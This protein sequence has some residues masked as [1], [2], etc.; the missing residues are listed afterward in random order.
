M[1]TLS[2][3]AITDFCKCPT[4]LT[5]SAHTS[6]AS[7]LAIPSR[8]VSSSLDLSFSW[9]LS[10]S[11]EKTWTNHKL[12]KCSLGATSSSLARLVVVFRS[13]RCLASQKRDKLPKLSLESLRRNLKLI[14]NKEVP[15]RTSPGVLSSATCTSATPRDSSMY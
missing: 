11:K 4:R 15:P 3:L 14:Q 10:S 8:S 5:L 9:L 12:R 6:Q 7:S 13:R 1:W 2:L